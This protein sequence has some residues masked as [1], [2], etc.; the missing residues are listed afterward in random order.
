VYIR[1]VDEL[2]FINYLT[3]MPSGVVDYCVD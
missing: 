3:D 1:K 2:L